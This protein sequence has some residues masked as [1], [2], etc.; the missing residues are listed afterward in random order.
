V[1]NTA[2]GNLAGSGA[3]FSRT[4]WASLV[5]QPSWPYLMDEF[6]DFMKKRNGMAVDS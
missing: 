3:L 4:G 2:G 6:V 1:L 5:Q